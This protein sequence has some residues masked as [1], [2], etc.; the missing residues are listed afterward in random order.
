MMSYIGA[1]FKGFFSS[2][3]GMLYDSLA[4]FLWIGVPAWMAVRKFNTKDL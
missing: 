4:M 3:W 2:Y 1:L